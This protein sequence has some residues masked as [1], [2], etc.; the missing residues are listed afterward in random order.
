MNGEKEPDIIYISTPYVRNTTKGGRR[1]LRSL[2]C[3]LG[4][5]VLVSACIVSFADSIGLSFAAKTEFGNAS[6][7]LYEDPPEYSI[8]GNAVSP[9]ISNSDEISNLE[10]ENSSFNPEINTNIASETD[11]EIDSESD[12]NSEAEQLPA[13][14]A[15]GSH[16]I[17]TTDLSRNPGADILIDNKTSYTPN[18]SDMLSSSCAVS[19]SARGDNHAQVTVT[20]TENSVLYSAGSQPPAV[21]IVHTHGTECYSQNGSTYSDAEIGF[22]SKD[23]DENMI[24]VGKKTAQS[25]SEF[26]I[27]VLHCTIMHD[28]ESYNDSYNYA[29]KSIKSFIAQYPS[30]SYVLDLHRDAIQY[31]DGS[32]ARPTIKTDLGDTAQLMFVIG[33]DELGANHPNWEKNLSLAVRL[34]SALNSKT[35]NLV[36]PISLRGAAYNEQYT[37]GSILVEVGACG[38]TLAEAENAAVLLADTLAEIILSGK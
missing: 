29:A 10:K 4:S 25:L 21:L 6:E 24:A 36:R 14:V 38:N 8:D 5:A 18:I 22:R 12:P 37:E 9:E 17:I 1:A 7:N 16:Q 2:C 19:G 34:Q 3:M 15:S 31:E 11:S 26:G 13:N 23:T 27:S 28:A 32:I 30:I 35:A 33:T 20:E